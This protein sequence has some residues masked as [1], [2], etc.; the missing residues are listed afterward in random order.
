V[1]DRVSPCEVFEGVL[2]RLPEVDVRSTHCRH[3]T[4][5]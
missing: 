3:F 2:R 4:A 1:R 5:V